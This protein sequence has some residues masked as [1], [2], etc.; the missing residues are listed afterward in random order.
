MR[1]STHWQ[2]LGYLASILSWVFQRYAVGV[3][4]TFDCHTGGKRHRVSC[5][6]HFMISLTVR[7]END[8]A[9]C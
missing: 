3:R 1:A 4:L 6:K 9:L 2:H 7:D 5:D 8:V